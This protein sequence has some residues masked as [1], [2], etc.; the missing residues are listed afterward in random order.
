MNTTLEIGP[1]LGQTGSPAGD[2]ASRVMKITTR[3]EKNECNY[4]G[5]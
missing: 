4:N 1:G 5:I 2:P 3:V